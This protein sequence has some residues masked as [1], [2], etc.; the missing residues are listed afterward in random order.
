M[1]PLGATR[2]GDKTPGTSTARRRGGRPPE[3]QPLSFK[4]RKRGRASVWVRHSGAPRCSQAVAPGL[5]GNHS[6]PENPHFT[7]LP[8]ASQGCLALG[9]SDSESRLKIW[10]QLPD[11]RPVRCPRHSSIPVAGNRHLKL[12]FPEAVPR[13]RTTATTKQ[14]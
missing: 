7:G 11:A 13:G 2:P 12:G 5:Q 9:A 3:K 6:A 10:R 8:E 14:P 1:G 4:E